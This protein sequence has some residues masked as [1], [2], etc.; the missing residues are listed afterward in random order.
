MS[1]SPGISQNLE[2]KV[3][4]LS[5]IC[6][7]P[8][9]DQPGTKMCGACGGRDS[10]CSSDCQKVDWKVH[11][12]FC[13]KVLPIGELPPKEALTYF[14]RSEIQKMANAAMDGDRNQLRRLDALIA[15]AGTVIYPLLLHF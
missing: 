13:A 6:A 3:S 12:L 9:C 2:E 10:Y 5:I 8:G 1:T 14:K 4:K 11:K 7:C 15:F